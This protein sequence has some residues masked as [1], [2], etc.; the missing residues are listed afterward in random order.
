[1]SEKKPKYQKLDHISH[2]LLRPETY[3]G[4]V[5]TDER[6][7]YVVE[8]IELN[9]IKVIKKKI[10]YNPAFIKLFDEIIVNASDQSIRSGKVKIIKVN[11]DDDKIMVENDGPSIPIELHPHENVY[12][13]ELIF[14]HLLTGENYDD[15]EERVV[16]GRNG[17]GAKLVSV[18]SSKFIIDCC[19]EKKKYKQIIKTN[20]RDINPPT[21]KDAN[22]EKSYT[23]ITYYPELSRFKLDKIDND[24]KSLM[25]KRCL[26][27]AV[28][29]PKVRVIVNGK[30]LPI[31]SVK[32]YMKM[33][34]SD[35]TELFYEKL[36]NGWEVGIAKSPT[37]QFEQVSIVN[38]ISTYKGGTHVNYISLQLAKDVS[39]SFS[40]KIK[41]NWLD[42]KNKVFL[43][44]ISQ[45][46]NP[47]FDS[48]TKENLMNYMSKEIHKGS[49]VSQS[50][51]KKIMK[52]EIVESILYALEQRE[53]EELRRL[54]KS[55]Q[56]VKIEKLVDANSKDRSK[57]SIAIF[58]GDSAGE[59][60]R[61]FRD[62]QTQAIFKL[63]GK[64]VNVSKT[65]DKQLL[66]NPKDNKPTEA[67][68]LI[69]ALGLELNKKVVKED[70]RFGEILLFMDMDVD[71]DSIVGLLLNFFSK[72]K[73][74]FDMGMIH[75]VVTPLLVIKKGKDKKYFYTSEEWE[76]YQKKNSISGWDVE[77]K[78][79]LGAL[80]DDEYEAMIKNP[81]KVKIV[82]DE[83]SK[84]FLEC[85]FGDDAEL[86][87]KQLS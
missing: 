5:N 34:I 17:L 71:G 7:M 77:Y 21:I 61:K 2:I 57:C 3:V 29:N 40:K 59:S 68:H 56:R 1:M 86:R 64:F 44:L 11:I 72:W 63:K 75:R 41:A 74:L 16:G 18:F 79:G 65:T 33:H 27:I 26:D 50:T 30:T 42:V 14:A 43:F 22:G 80:E 87:K 24:S 54:Q 78:K 35:D 67:A 73:E 28:Y 37:E 47:E 52:S 49:Q 82:W 10:S 13:P 45:I 23:S 55:Q 60:T 25:I 84:M 12:N 38:G 6:E 15:T 62:P 66:V 32:D 9:E 51:I 36:D 85:W 39:D 53:K 83:E 69:N 4:S 19:D 48:Q 81:K 70:L 46:P 8:D 58:E 76:E 31:K 20:M